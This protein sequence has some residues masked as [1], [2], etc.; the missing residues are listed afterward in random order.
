MDVP[1]AERFRDAMRRTASGATPPTARIIATAQ[2]GAES[3][4]V[5]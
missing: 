4:T 3:L 2:E 5:D 1:I